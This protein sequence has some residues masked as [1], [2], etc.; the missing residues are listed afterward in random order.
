MKTSDETPQKSYTI[1]LQFPFTLQHPARPSRLPG[2][3]LEVLP[4]SLSLH[5]M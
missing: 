3:R 1:Y 4:V 2:C 5:L